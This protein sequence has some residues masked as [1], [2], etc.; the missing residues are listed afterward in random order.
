MSQYG[1]LPS[2]EQ[3]ILLELRMLRAFGFKLRMRRRVGLQMDIAKTNWF[4]R[5]A[6]QLLATCILFCF[7]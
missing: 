7:Q 3:S 5:N 4:N 6:P 1:I 2:S